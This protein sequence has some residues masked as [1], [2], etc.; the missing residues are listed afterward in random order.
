MGSATCMT[1]TSCLSTLQLIPLR[2]VQVKASERNFFTGSATVVAPSSVIIRSMDLTAAETRIESV[3]K[4]ARKLDP[5]SLLRFRAW[6]CA[7]FDGCGFPRGSERDEYS[8]L[9]TI[10]DFEHEDMR[11][12]HKFARH[13]SR[14]S[15]WTVP[16][17]YAIA[18]DRDW[19]YVG[20]ARRLSTRR[21]NHGS[22]L[23]S[24]THANRLLQRHWDVDSDPMWFVVLEQLGADVAFR[25]G[26]EHPRELVW[27]RRLR[28][29][30]DREQRRGDISFL[31]HPV[32]LPC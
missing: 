32:L 22:T 11:I 7:A 24:G 6:V 19:L 4:E 5:E 15:A 30:Y 8:A 3:Q 23:R 31:V 17:I 28:P 25:R 12:L 21:I 16:G 1:C 10:R 29:L 18:S 27:K 9:Y 26:A 14:Y 20:R 13:T 2:L